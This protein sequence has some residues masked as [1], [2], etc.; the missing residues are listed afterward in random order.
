MANREKKSI[1]TAGHAFRQSVREGMREHR[2]AFLILNFLRILVILTMVRFIMLRNYEGFFMCVLILLLFYI[3]ALVKLTFH[4][5]VPATLEIITFFFIFASEFLGELNAFFVVIPFWD[6][7]LHAFSGFIAAAI[8]FSLVTVLNNNRSLQFSLSPM[9]MAV[10]SFC[11]AMTIGVFWEF[12]EYVWDWL[13]HTDM[14]KDSVIHAIYSVALDPTRSKKVIGITGIADV[15][16][17]GES[18]GLGGYLDIGLVDTMGDLFVS[19]IGAFTF[20]VYGYIYAK[21]KGAKNVLVNRL[22]LTP[23]QEEP[24]KENEIST[25]IQEEKNEE[26]H[27]Y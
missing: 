19:F 6:V 17:N 24:G 5:E 3:P 14:Q 22:V 18:L 23:R 10:V 21:T 26:D 8:G 2:S 12:F 20:S 25:E 7:I 1:R 13:F 9:F 11:F 15:I 4:V 16:V 27:A